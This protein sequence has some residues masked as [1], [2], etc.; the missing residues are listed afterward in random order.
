[1]ELQAV[2]KLHLQLSVQHLY[3]H[4]YYCLSPVHLALT[5]SAAVMAQMAATVFPAVTAQMA[6]QYS[7]HFLLTAYLAAGSAVPVPIAV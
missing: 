5:E 4:H 6:H 2:S 1:M 3:F 7:C